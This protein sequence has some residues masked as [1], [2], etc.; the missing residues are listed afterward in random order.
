MG[1]PGGSTANDFFD[2]VSD[3]VIAD[4]RCHHIAYVKSG[5]TGEAFVDG[6]SVD[7]HTAHFTLRD[8][9]RYSFGQEWDG[10]T[11]SDHYEG[12]MDEIRVWSISRTK[13]EIQA[14]MNGEV[15]FDSPGLTAYYR[16]NDGVAL[17]DNGG[18]VTINDDRL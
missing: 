8:F 1:N 3:V 7:T 2:I 14:D 17:A 18:L 11:D 12:I 4:G 16:L 5:S 9:Q 6:V 10:D 13:A 15:A